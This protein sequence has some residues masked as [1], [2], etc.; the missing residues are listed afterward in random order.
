MQKDTEV[1]KF[2]IYSTPYQHYHIN[3]TD[4]KKSTKFNNI[5]ITWD[6]MSMIV[7]K[8]RNS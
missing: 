7:M 8:A 1:H 3:F 2:G 6:K 5:D 4:S